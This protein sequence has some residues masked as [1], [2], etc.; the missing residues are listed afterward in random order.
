MEE[1]PGIRTEGA[2]P[3]KAHGGTELEGLVYLQS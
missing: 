3:S 2:E 1:G